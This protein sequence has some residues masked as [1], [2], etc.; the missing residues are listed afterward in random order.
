M[1]AFWP[2]HHD[3]KPLLRHR[4]TVRY[5]KR[6]C[7]HRPERANGCFIAPTH[8]KPPVTKRHITN[9]TAFS[10]LGYAFD[11]HLCR[12]FQ[13]DDA[14]S[15]SRPQGTHVHQNGN[16]NRNA[17]P[18]EHDGL[19][20]AKSKACA[21]FDRPGSVWPCDYVYQALLCVHYAWSQARF[22]AQENMSAAKGAVSPGER[23]L[24]VKTRV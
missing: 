17:S 20:T 4:S 11:A 21:C 5:I 12:R 19:Q 23:R 24:L 3:A 22:A 16:Q 15:P 18:P 10:P 8:A 2:A 13:S 6:R 7:M 14:G 9:A 1:Q